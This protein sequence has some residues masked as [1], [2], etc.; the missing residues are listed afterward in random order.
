MNSRK[1][2]GAGIAAITVLLLALA[3]CEKTFDDKISTTTDLNSAHVQLFVATVNANRNVIVMDGKRVSRP[4]L[5]SGTG[6][7]FAIYPSTGAG[8]SFTVPGGLH[9]FSI[10]DTLATTTQRPLIFAATLEASK[11]YTIFTY[12]TI[13]SPKQVTVETP[14]EI[15]SDGSARLRFAN[16]IHDANAVPAV[17]VFSKRR[18]EVI[19]TNVNKTD[20]TNFI[21]FAPLVVDTLVIREVGA[22][23]VL[24]Q[25]NGFVPT[26]TRSYTLVYRGSQPRGT[27]PGTRTATVFANY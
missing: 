1:I 27:Y 12:D 11:M 23:A 26:G 15:P 19:F 22:T 8:T 13:T 2:T 16:F 18:N 7:P 3:S 14:I 6:F 24:A 5:T 25:F 10:A 9:S 21:S 17:E 20:V 4:T